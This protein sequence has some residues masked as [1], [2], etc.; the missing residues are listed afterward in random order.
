MEVIVKILTET[1]GADASTEQAS[2]IRI[3]IILGGNYL[4]FPTL[5]IKTHYPYP[6]QKILLPTTLFL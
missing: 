6:P 4:V 3:C 1:F 5:K 2:T